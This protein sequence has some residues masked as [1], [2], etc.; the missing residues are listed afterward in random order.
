MNWIRTT[1]QKPCPVCGKPDWCLIAPDNSAAICARIEEDAIKKCGDAG[2]LHILKNRHNGHYKHN[3]PVNKRRLVKD[4]PKG[5]I[6]SK[7]FAYLAE[8]YK[9]LLTVDKLNGL[10]TV[11]GVS[12]ASLNRLNIGWDGEAYTFPMSNNFGSIIGI[13]RRFP[14]SR[15]VSVKGSKNGLFIPQGLSADGFL[16]VC[17]GVSDTAAA[18]NLGFSAIGRPNCNS[19]IEM[20]VKAASSQKEIVIAGD[21]DNVGKSGARRLADAM[22]LHNPCVKVIHPPDNIKDLRKWLQSGLTHEMLQQIIKDAR[23]I[24]LA[25]SFK[26]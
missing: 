12:G 26:E 9:Q 16:L 7:N 3:Y 15:K 17:E 1:R 11:L 23:P 22:A 13:R 25:I 21:N 8:R 5:N 20:T 6:S 19:K 4:V 2:Y 24:E 18:L 10:A 14:N